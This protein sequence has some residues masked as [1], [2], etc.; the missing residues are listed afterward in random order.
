MFF[1]QAW[2]E[3]IMTSRYRSMSGKYNFARD[4]RRGVVE[5]QA[6]IVHAAGNGFEERESAVTFIQVQNTGCDSHCAQR[7]ESTYTKHKFLA[8]SGTA[9]TAIKTRRYLA[10]FRCVA[11]YIRIQKQKLAA[12]NTHTPDLQI[13]HTAAGLDFYFDR[14][15][16]FAD[17]GFHGQLIDVG[18][19]VLFLLPAVH[20]EVL[21][22]ISLPIKK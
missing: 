2:M 22:E 5:V 19:D 11:F 10:V 13:N 17:G 4:A 21:A 1:H 14:L 7:T 12:A 9:I 6:F 16:V 8:N 15:T 18:V 20:V 3:A